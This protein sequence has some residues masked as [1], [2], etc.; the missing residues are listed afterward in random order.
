MHWS[1]YNEAPMESETHVL[2]WAQGGQVP[3]A[4]ELA[5][6]RYLILPAAEPQPSAPLLVVPETETRDP[7]AWRLLL[8]LAPAH[9]TELAAYSHGRPWVPVDELMKLCG[10]NPNYRNRADWAEVALFAPDVLSFGKEQD[11]A[12]AVLRLWNRLTP[13]HRQRWRVLFEER[14][15]RKNFIREIIADFYD[16]GSFVRDTILA[17]AEAQS[18]SWKAR[19]RPFP[20]EKFRDL[21][22][23]ARYPRFEES[24]ALVEEARRAFPKLAGVTLDVPAHLEEDSLTLQLRFKSTE[25]LAALLDS[26]QDHRVN[27]SLRELLALL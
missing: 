21:V 13:Q 24:R 17:E 19:S 10:L 2:P 27:G 23:S 25:E 14:H 18:L 3:V 11:F 26:L 1:Q 8:Q 15:L 9:Y 5:D 20:G 7:Q 22:R 6:A 16:L 4:V 12:P